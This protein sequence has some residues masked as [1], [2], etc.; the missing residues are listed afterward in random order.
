MTLPDV[1]P[2]PV[3][4]SAPPRFGGP[5]DWWALAVMA[6]LAFVVRLVPL[7]IGGGLGF[8]GRYDDGVYYSAADALG[9]GRIP[10]RE[11]VMLHPPGI[12]LVLLPFA[13]LG[14]LTTDLAGLEVARLA[15]MAVAAVNT[16]LVALIARRWGRPAM[17]AGGVMYACWGSAA[18][19]EQSTFL[20]PIGG[21]C[22]LLAL[23][24]LVRP[25][26]LPSLRAEWLA[27]VVLGLA[28]SVK[29][30]YVAPWAVL[31]LWL[32]LARRPRSA[33]R[34]VA[35]GAASLTVVVVPFLI[36]SRGRMY[37]FVVRDQL[38]RPTAKS[39]RA[40]RIPGM[41][42][43]RSFTDGHSQ[44]RHVFAAILIVLLIT[45]FVAAIR[46]RSAWPLVAV[47]LVNAAVLF[48][49]P[50]YFRHYAS[51][52]AGPA[53]A[54]IGIGV[55]AAVSGRSPR[56]IARPLFA[57]ALALM[58]A[59]GVWIALAAEGQ[60]FPGRAFAAAAPPGCVAADDPAA[61]IEMNRLSADFRHHCQVAVDVSGASYDWVSRTGP[62]GKPVARSANPAWKAY[63][64]NY[65]TNA[66][67]FVIARPK[68]D[69]M[70]ALERRRYAGFTVL[71]RTPT[72]ALRRGTGMDS[73][74]GTLPR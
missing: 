38:F 43:I 62:D 36:A 57:G 69:A 10:Y 13:L 64:F 23:W 6:V 59:S 32:L 49:G 46:Q 34:V 33:L 25:D 16:V 60:T 61:L 19:A 2:D 71:A 8:Y 29:I 39:P 52:F 68:G 72:M 56:R 11:F 67:A 54:V 28:E 18:Y 70:S 20:E 65:L 7:L 9:F 30:W 66:N 44:L 48:I 21:L 41:L 35:G 47:M 15:F 24:L 17:L 74:P 12:M 58:L 53:A 1:A 50:V 40:G 5:P 37:D 27:G 26:R 73:P 55:G 42:G 4:N 45:F 31:V 3:G 14:R 22:V 51:F 63:L